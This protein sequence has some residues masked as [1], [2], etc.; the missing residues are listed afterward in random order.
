[1]GIRKVSREAFLTEQF[2]EA[3]FTQIYAEDYVARKDGAAFEK[4]DYYA[5]GKAYKSKFAPYY[6][7]ADI[8]INGIFYDKSSPM[9]FTFEELQK[10]DF[11]I[12]AIA[13]VTCDI[14][15]DASVPCT[16]RPSK[17]I[18][19]V[20]GFSRTTGEEIAPFSADSID[21]MAVDNLPSELP[22]DA[23]AFFGEQLIE[24]ILP[25]LL[26]QSGSEVIGRAMITDGGELTSAFNYLSA[27]VKGA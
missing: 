22:R 10:S 14:M 27:Y 1:M 23:S 26:K 21:I 16:I 6:R 5:N 12:R 17:I 2:T 8:F 25:E 18:S 15:P 13:D 20:F 4:A 7:K 11:Q 3:V 19:P 24:N 9:F